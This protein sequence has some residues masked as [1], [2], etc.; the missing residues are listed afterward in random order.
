MFVPSND[1]LM[2]NTD[3]LINLV[4]SQFVSRT[5]IEGNSSGRDFMS[6][7]LQHSMQNNTLWFTITTTE[8]THNITVPIPFVEN[9]ILFVRNNGIKRAVCNHY[10]VITERE[11]NYLDAIQIIFLGDFSGFIDTVTSKKTMF[12][13]QL[14]YAILNKNLSVVVYSLQKAINELVNKMPLHETD[15]NSWVMNNR[16]MMIDPMFEGLE[17]PN[18]RLNYQ[19]MK[20]NKYF[21]NGWTSI[22]LSDGTLADKNYILKTDLR[23]YT[24]FGVAHHNP[25]RNLYSTLGMK[26]DEYPRIKSASMDDLMSHG[27]A[28]KGWNFVTVYA[29]IPDTFEDQIVIDNS[30]RDKFTTKERRVQ[31]FGNMAV[32]EGEHVKYGQTLAISPDGQKEAFKVYAEDAWVKS[33]RKVNV[34][35]GGLDKEAYEVIIVLK[36]NLKDG[37]KLTNM[38][39]NKGVVHFE[40]IGYATNPK[41]GEKIKIDIVVSAKTIGKR[42]NHGQVLELLFN[43]ML[44]FE[45]SENP[46]VRPISCSLGGTDGFGATTGGE[47]VVPA[48]RPITIPNDRVVTDVELELIDAKHVSMGFKKGSVLECDTYAGKFDALCG[49]VFWGVIKDAEDQLW[50]PGATTAVNGK[51]LRTAGLKF[52]TVEFRA[53]ET[54]FGEKNPVMDEVL[55]YVQGTDVVADLAEVLR[56]KMGI[57]NSKRPVINPLSVRIVDQS[58]GTLFKEESLAGTV[59][60][61]FFYGDGCVIQLP[62]KFQTAVGIGMT[63]T[64]EGMAAFTEETYD[65]ENYKA[66]YTTDKL[67]VPSGL[68]RRPW[69]HASGLFGMSEAAVLLN[70]III[71]CKRMADEP[72]E[73]R[74]RNMLYNGIQR[75]YTS[76]AHSLS[77]KRGALATQAMSVRY[78]YSAKAVATLTNKIPM[79]HVEIHS[80]MAK[81]LNVKDGD[82]VLI[83]RFPCLGF[84]GLRVQKVVVTDDPMCRFTIR[85]SKNSL[86]STNL[87]FDGDVIYIASFHT[88]EARAAL[89]RE[90]AAPAQAYWKYVDKL[91]NRKGGPFLHTMN[92]QDYGIKPFPAFTAESHAQVVGKLTGVKAQT[93]PVI[94]M[95]YNVTRVVESSGEALDPDM[96]AGIE[97]FIEKAGQSVFE[98]KHG[99][100]S[101]HGIVLDAI[102]KADVDALAEEGFDRKVA[103][104]ICR[105][106]KRKAN[107]IGVPDLATFHEKKGATIVSKIV[108]ANN[109]LY[110][111]SRAFLEGCELLEYINTPVVDLPSR[112][113]NLTMSGT[114]SKKKTVL[115]KDYD[116]RLINQVG[117]DFKEACAALFRCIDTVVGFR[118]ESVEINKAELGQLISTSGCTVGA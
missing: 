76:I 92:L 24:P 71:F 19:I 37:T 5:Q 31:C 93:G 81:Q 94:A 17:D 47:V 96:R 95:A 46:I 103:D 100:Q 105:I 34:S 85:A 102:C 32:K 60:D 2:A 89:E 56:S 64:Y 29:D 51:G 18:D 40:D 69:K 41:T 118:R 7:T 55:S 83:E 21:G 70:N 8:E 99:G 50:A 67:F 90:W 104:F 9:G 15:M 91:N 43:N 54:I 48:P 52:S 80:E 63:P 61:E 27:I 116:N 74:H 1:S 30:H 62:V 13:Q 59:A 82:P 88:P 87:D 42:K 11:L 79:H 49:K 108:R 12:V 114:Y 39:G 53:L 28:R 117:D 36:R 66:L 33:I 75:Y 106:I 107:E 35:V 45:A 98:Q 25:Q 73:P 57:V 112:I 78:P 111:A 14:A 77:M 10:D 23:M 65:R 38:H 115:D 109:K 26:G 16:L 6:A 20:N 4:T 110:Y 84:M 22:G 58:A 72:E 68:L 101:L 113:F 3:A 86:V 97:M 44:E